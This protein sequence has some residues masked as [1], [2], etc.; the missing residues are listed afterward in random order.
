MYTAH[1]DFFITLGFLSF[2]ERNATQLNRE[3][4]SKNTVHSSN[5]ITTCNG[6]MFKWTIYELFSWLCEFGSW[7]TIHELGQLRHDRSI[8]PYLW[9]APL[10]LLFSRSKRTDQPFLIMNI[11]QHHVSAHMLGPCRL[12]YRDDGLCAIQKQLPNLGPYISAYIF[13]G[14]MYGSYIW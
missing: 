11:I 13:L 7:T 14:L 3:N 4:V 6:L 5:A 8:D 12:T 1:R 9:N 10:G 2:N